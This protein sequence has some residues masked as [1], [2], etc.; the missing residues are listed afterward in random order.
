MEKLNKETGSLIKPRFFVCELMNIEGADMNLNESLPWKLRK[1][2][3]PLLLAFFFHLM[4][5][6][7]TSE[8]K[9]PEQVAKSEPVSIEEKWGIKVVSVRL[10]AADH[11]IDF[12]Y[13]I[14]DPDKATALVQKQVKP[15]LLDQAT[16]TKMGVPRTRLGPMRQSSVKPAADRNYAILFGNT[17]KLI[18]QG[19]RVTV[20][21]G[22]LK[23]EDL[24]V[25]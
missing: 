17:G 21:I 24:V 15:Y 3:G 1:I 6:A 7:T 4:G 12:R 18:K 14:L 10:T 19:S 13:R 11:M 25:E 5:C 8:N 20:V 22:D 9:T 2:L 23:V 16:G